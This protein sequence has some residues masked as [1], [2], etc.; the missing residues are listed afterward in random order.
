[1]WNLLFLCSFPKFGIGKTN[2]YLLDLFPDF[3]E[4][5]GSKDHF[6]GVLCASGSPVSVINFPLVCWNLIAFSLPPTPELERLLWFIY[7]PHMSL[8]LFHWESL[9]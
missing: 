2:F 3:V 1:M 7:H 5:Q 8:A 9:V 4:Q 6:P